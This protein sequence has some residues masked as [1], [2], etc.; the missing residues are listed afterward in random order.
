MEDDRILYEEFLNG[1]EKAFEKI[2]IKYRSGLI[3]FISRYTKNLEVAE[4]LFQDVMLYVME[5]KDYYNFQYSFKSYMYM[6][7]KS[8]SLDFIRKNN[9]TEDISEK[10]DVIK[11]ELLLE[12]IILTKERQKKIQNVI[13][14]MSKE[15]QI[16]IYLTQIEGLSYKETAIVMDKTDR[17]I[18][19]LAFNARKKLKQL[20]IKEKVVEIKNNKIIRL[21]VLILL[22]TATISGVAYATWKLINGKI[23][24]TEGYEIDLIPDGVEYTLAI[25][26]QQNDN[27]DMKRKEEYEKN[28]FHSN[29]IANVSN[30]IDTQSQERNEKINIKEN[31]ILE[32]LYDYYTKEEIDILIQN[33]NS[34]SIDNGKYIFSVHA[35]ELLEK[36]VIILE[37]ENITIGDKKIL[38]DFILQVDLTELKNSKLKTRIDSVLKIEQKN[39]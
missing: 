9:R 33:I 20:L 23:L 21:I 37:N 32:I 28:M 17:Q 10:E 4:D 36:V 3:Y 11:D 25:S 34:E 14:K 13:K 39:K 19:N 7:A 24:V 26:S 15:Y 6:I 1:N 18:K 27:E 38:E 35:E 8:K 22:I 2:I 29:N 16:V 30:E 12:E 5:H 31:V